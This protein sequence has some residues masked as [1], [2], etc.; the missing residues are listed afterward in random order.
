MGIYSLLRNKSHLNVSFIFG[1][2]GRR[3]PEEDTTSL[4][5]GIVGSYPNFIFKVNIGDF[6]LY[7]TEL[8]KV[9][10][11]QS[12]TRFVDKF[13]IRRTDERI[14]KTIDDIHAYKWNFLNDAGLLDFSRYLNL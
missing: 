1:E 8:R 13:G 12:M 4:V 3:V 2:E 11:K 6:N 14:W 7:A 10:S 5:D 9:K